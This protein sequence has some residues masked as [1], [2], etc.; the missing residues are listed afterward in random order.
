MAG[1]FRS[2][3]ES[4]G[5]KREL[6]SLVRL[7]GT[8]DLARRVFWMVTLFRRTLDRLN[9]AEEQLKTSGKT[10]SQQ[11]LD[12]DTELREVKRQFGLQQAY[13]E[14]MFAAARET[15]DHE[16][17]DH[18]RD[19]KRAALEYKRREDAL[20]EDNDELHRKV[21]DLEDHIRSLENRLQAG[22]LN[23]PRVMNFLNRGKTRVSGNW[24][25]LKALFELFKD[26]QT[27]PDAWATQ[28]LVNAVDNFGAAPGPYVFEH[29]GDTDEE[30]KS[31]GDPKQ[32][33]ASSKSRHGASKDKPVDLTIPPSSPSH[34]PR[35]SSRTKTSGSKFL[36]AATLAAPQMRP[37]SWKPNE[38][39]ARD[40]REAPVRSVQEARASLKD[41]PIVWNKLR[42]N[43]QLVMQS[44]LD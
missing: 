32:G 17:N 11:L 9:R 33:D 25:R 20:Q 23:V 1:E 35:K 28:I 40:P 7:Y 44:G 37:T 43:V 18:A 8:Q 21:E 22:S 2:L 27:V 10:T 41:L 38:E 15:M 13:F 26:H 16:A 4:P 6:A 29:D 12:A 36:K 30:E 42:T 31:G 14:R 3:L 39:D 24:P 19:F 5:A 34:T